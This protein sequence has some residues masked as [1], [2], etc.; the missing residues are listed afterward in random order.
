M[1]NSAALRA[2]R[3]P[4]QMFKYLKYIIFFVVYTTLPVAAWRLFGAPSNL[5]FG[6]HELISELVIAV[7]LLR[8]Y[9]KGPGYIA[10]GLGFLVAMLAD[11]VYMLTIVNPGREF[12]FAFQL[13]ELLYI[14]FYAPLTW[15]FF[16][17]AK[18][19]APDG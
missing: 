9:K 2:R 4:P 8:Q 1:L 15:F 13:T 17:R 16:S 10:M 18:H 7:I 19:L 6:I 11:G 14:A 5:A 12:S 3:L